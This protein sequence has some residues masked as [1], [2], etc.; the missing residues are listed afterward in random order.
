MPVIFDAFSEMMG[1]GHA[2]TTLGAPRYLRA[3]VPSLKIA[4]VLW[5]EVDP[6]KKAVDAKWLDGAGA[7]YAVFTPVADNRD[8][9]A[10]HAES[11][12]RIKN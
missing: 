11:L 1:G 7:D 3:G 9:C 10:V 2:R 4:S 8:P 12:K 5:L 6:D